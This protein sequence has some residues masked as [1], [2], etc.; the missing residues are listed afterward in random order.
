MN[1]DNR[2]KTP[3]AKDPFDGSFE[4]VLNDAF[5]RMDPSREAEERMLAAVIA[6]HN[7]R[8][9]KR[10]RQP[11]KIALPIAACLVLFAG[12]GALA[13]NVITSSYQ[14]M[15]NTLGNASSAESAGS[16]DP[17]DTDAS[18]E[19]QS[20]DTTDSD[21]SEPAATD[22]T[23]VRYSII[24]LASGEQLRIVLTDTGDPVL[25]DTDLV[26]EEIGQAVAFDETHTESVAC[27]VFVYGDGVH[28]YAVR[29]EGDEKIYL[30]A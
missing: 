16:A 28:P 6:A 30:A 12:I 1:R 4:H 13:F 24:E 26:G 14:Q 3:V 22:D 29:Y 5:G 7:P 23:D 20:D 10:G 9:V 25:G 18:G 15:S 2:F 8:V 17:G 27:E 11:W 19:G 21:L